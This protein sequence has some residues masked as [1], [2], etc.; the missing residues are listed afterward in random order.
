MCNST[1]TSIEGVDS[2]RAAG[3]RIKS[4]PDKDTTRK[5]NRGGEKGQHL[6]EL[7]QP[8]PTFRF[9][10]HCSFTAV[11]PIDSS[12]EY[13][14]RTQYTR[15]IQCIH[16]LYFDFQ[17]NIPMG[18]AQEPWLVRVYD[19]MSNTIT[20]TRSTLLSGIF[21]FACLYTQ[22]F[23]SKSSSPSLYPQTELTQDASRRT[24]IFTSCLGDAAAPTITAVSRECLAS[25]SV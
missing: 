22:I 8:P 7:T 20:V 4:R 5:Q 13:E 11:A 6:A 18:S 21:I 9:G 10:L 14:W 15:C 24:R 23:P 2:G 16:T 25:A 1:R 12:T 19:V 3:V 17:D